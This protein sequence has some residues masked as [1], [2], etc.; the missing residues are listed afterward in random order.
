MKANKYH[1]FFFFFTNESPVSHTLD[2]FR[3]NL[4]KGGP[5]ILACDFKFMI[6]LISW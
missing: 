2:Y 5:K 4:C 3:E 6:L 1:Y